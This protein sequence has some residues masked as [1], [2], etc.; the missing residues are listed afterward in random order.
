MTPQSTSKV[1]KSFS[2]SAANN[3]ER[4]FR[5]IIIIWNVRDVLDCNAATE[6]RHRI[7][8]SPLGWRSTFDLPGMF[9]ACVDHE[10][11]SDAAIPVGKFGGVI[12][13]TIFRSSECTRPNPPTPIRRICDSQSEEICRSK[14]RSLVTNYWGHYVAALRHPENA[15]AVVLRSPVSPL[16][17]IHVDKGT[18]SVFFSHLDDCI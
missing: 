1:S 3:R 2:A 5:Y 4:M 8:N 7:R 10:F 6:L 16:A 15:G 14:G 13:G 9:V 12:L 18:L 11:S 17:C